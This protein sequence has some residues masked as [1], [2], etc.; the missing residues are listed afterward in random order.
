MA[1]I[2]S[3]IYWLSGSALVELMTTN[4]A[5]RQQAHIYLIWVIII[6]LSGMLAF[7]LDGVFIG[8]TW[9]RDMSIMMI[10][11]LA[12]YFAVWFIVEEQLGNHGLWLAIHFFLI[13]RALTL[14]L[15]LK[16]KVAQTFN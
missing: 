4:E 3:L 10:V 14:A 2:L 6:P 15:R 7:Q 13:M 16:P 12:T 1:G 11:S 5:V 9:S 8:A